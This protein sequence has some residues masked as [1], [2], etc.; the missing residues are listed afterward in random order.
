MNCAERLVALFGTQAEVARRFRLDRAV[1]NNWVKCGY[2][3]S[4]WA[5]EVEHVTEG[6]VAAVEVLNEAATMK[7]VRVK[8]RGDDDNLFGSSLQGDAMNEF[9]PVKR[10]ASFH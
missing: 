7:P 2:V 3:P 5:M 6:K 8:S 9:A 10:I 4:R 1:V